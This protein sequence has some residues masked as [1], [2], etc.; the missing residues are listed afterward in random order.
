MKPLIVTCSLYPSIEEV[1]KFAS[2]LNPIFVPINPKTDKLGMQLLFIDINAVKMLSHL[3]FLNKKV[4][5]FRHIRRRIRGTEYVLH[6]IPGCSS[7]AA[8]G[9]ELKK[10][11]QRRIV[12]SVQFRNL[13]NF[14]KASSLSSLNPR[15]RAPWTA[16]PFVHH[17][18]AFGRILK[19]GN[20][21]YGKAQ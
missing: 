7:A 20:V 16:T 6:C 14:R 1:Q 18:A 15:I 10:Q 17:C 19:N 5:D 2:G 8:K 13:L 21:E 11:H 9:T 3:R 12:V 4:H